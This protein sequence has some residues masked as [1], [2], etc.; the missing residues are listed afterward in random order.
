MA[1]IL[2]AAAPGLAGAAR[3]NNGVACV[4]FQLNVILFASVS[5]MRVACQSNPITS[6]WKLIA[7]YAC[8][9]PVIC[10]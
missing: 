8:S 9:L 6:G 4:F 7:C 10:F 2:A 1:A 3:W 5:T